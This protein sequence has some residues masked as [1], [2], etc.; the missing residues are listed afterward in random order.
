M[1]KMNPVLDSEGTK[2]LIALVKG[3]RPLADSE[4]T[5]DKIAD[6]SVTADKL[7][8][9]L[10]GQIGSYSLP[11]ATADR[12]GGVKVGSGLAVTAD[13]TLSVGL[14]TLTDDEFVTYVT[15]GTEG[16]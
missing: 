10:R 1:A 6:G 12:L 13:G 15:T 11:T 9:E 3:A 2:H 14:G 7:S 5:T 8:D 4:V 16:A